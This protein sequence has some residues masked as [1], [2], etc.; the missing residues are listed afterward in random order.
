VVLI[1]KIDA[2]A[3]FDFDLQQ[4]VDRI[5]VCN[6][7]IPVFAVSAETGDGMAAWCTWLADNVTAFL[8][9]KHG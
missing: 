8:E 2:I 7:C 3:V 4:A 5:H 9:G 1:N 6:P